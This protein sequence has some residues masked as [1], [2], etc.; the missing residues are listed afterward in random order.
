MGMNFGDTESRHSDT[1]R[2]NTLQTLCPST[3]VWG[4]SVQNH[5]PNQTR[6]NETPTWVNADVRVSRDFWSGAGTLSVRKTLVLIVDYR[7]CPP[8]YWEAYTTMGL[9]YG[10]KWFSNH[11]PDFFLYGGMFCFL[12]NI[13]S[14]RE[15]QRV[16]PEAGRFRV[17]SLSVSECSWS[18]L[19]RATDV[20][21]KQDGGVPW[22][23]TLGSL[24]VSV[25]NQN[26]LS[27]L[28]PNYPFIICYLHTLNC[29]QNALSALSSFLTGPI[30]P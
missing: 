22:R 27:A 28:D 12:P 18:P 24:M 5:S 3:R 26:A 30:R 8:V 2:M 19:F 10:N 11:L 25:C 23:L 4:V 7:W 16:H 29:K 13:P 1:V 20:A 15:M 14:I 21:T 17:E 9:G 6:I